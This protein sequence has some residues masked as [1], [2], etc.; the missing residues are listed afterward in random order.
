MTWENEAS[1]LRCTA[2]AGQVSGLSAPSCER[3]KE[4]Q[5]GNESPSTVIDWSEMRCS[6]VFSLL[7]YCLHLTEST[8]GPGDRK[9]VARAPATVSPPAPAPS[10]ASTVAPIPLSEEPSE[11]VSPKPLP[12][13][14]TNVLQRDLIQEEITPRD[15]LQNHER[16]CSVCHETREFTYPTLIYITPWNNRGYDLVKVFTKKFDY[17][18]PVWF[19]VKRTSFEKYIIEGTHD[20]DVKWIETL[21]GNH[22]DL[23]I[24]PRVVFE[25]WPVANVHALLQSEDEKQQVAATLVNLLVEYNH[26]F[27]GYVLDLLIQFRGTDKAT[28]HHLIRDI[29]ERI[30]QID[31]NGTTK[32]KEVF[33]LVPPAAELFDRTD[34]YGLR[35]YVDGF[36][37]MTFDFP[38]K[39]PGPVSPVGRYSTEKG[40]IPSL[41]WIDDF[42]LI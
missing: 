9:S 5:R 42:R 41:D 21:K 34:Y 40:S 6:L 15:I 39:E 3:E 16:Y 4:K 7:C 25:K 32:R 36:S 2:A 38:T 27:D 1:S 28:I 8:L 13:E 12:L 19:S 26:L 24:V 35:E 20:I 31:N 33:L 30:H 11:P 37:V 17:I 18:S 10:P 23:R 22:P 14:E 29:T